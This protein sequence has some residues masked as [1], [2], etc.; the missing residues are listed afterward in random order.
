MKR[1]YKKVSVTHRGGLYYPQL[2]GKDIKTPL[3]TVLLSPI[4][5][6]ADEISREWDAQKE[7]IV[8]DT[9][10]FTQIVSTR[11]DKITGQR[12]VITQQ[13]MPYIDGDTIL[14]HSSDKGDLLARQQNQWTPW[15]DWANQKIG[16]YYTLQME[17]SA[18]SQEKEI[19]DYWTRFIDGLD[20]ERL[21]LFQALVSLTASPILSAAFLEKELNDEAV[22]SLSHLEELFQQESWGLDWEAE[23]KQNKK[24]QELNAYYRYLNFLS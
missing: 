6:I 5:D 21:T 1:F 8:P 20:D 14:Y 23:D 15:V 16:S 19:H 11:L 17:L 7:T 18:T 12:D 3:K 22:F 13:I 4:Q 9:M 10:P 2:D 24:K